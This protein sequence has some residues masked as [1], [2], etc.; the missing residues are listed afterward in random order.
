MEV[1]VEQF[2]KDPNNFIEKSIK[3]YIKS[4]PRN[5]FEDGGHIYDEPLVGFADGDDPI[6]QD[7]KKIIGDF[8]LTPREAL[9]MH[10]QRTGKWSRQPAHFSVIAWILPI[11]YETRL[12]LRNET[13][14]TS[15]RWH[16]TRLYGEELNE[17]LARYVV[18]L[19]EQAGHKAVAPACS[20]SFKRM[21]MPNGPSSNWSQRHSCY[22][23]GLGTF[24]LSDGLI[25]PRGIAMRC[26]TAVCDIPL[27]PTPR[28]YASHLANCLFYLDR[29]C[30]RC[31]ERCPAGAIT[32]QGHDKNKCRDY[33][34]VQREI[35]KRQGKAESYIGTHMGCGFCQTKVPCETRIPAPKKK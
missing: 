23:A 11:A 34:A 4:S 10:Y 8:H 32:E 22:A 15:L 27:I 20:D 2:E 25:T 7:Y 30:R 26:G 12:S 21:Q 5:R 16:L 18:A 3:E 35:I 28:T 17:E 9:E 13:E 19:I 1:N 24:S 33:S 6:F 14:V 29:S 31:I